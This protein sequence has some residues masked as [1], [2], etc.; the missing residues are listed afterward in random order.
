MLPSTKV[1]P[2]PTFVNVSV[3]LLLN[4]L[5]GGP[6]IVLFGFLGWFALIVG[7]A[8]GK[9]GW[10]GPISR[11]V[12]CCGGGCYPCFIVGN[13]AWLLMVSRPARRI[14]TKEYNTPHC[15]DSKSSNLRWCVAKS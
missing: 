2:F 4:G 7:V 14:A 15:Q 10:N 3:P 8:A 13:T 12:A 11:L 6:G 5:P 9:K 1:T